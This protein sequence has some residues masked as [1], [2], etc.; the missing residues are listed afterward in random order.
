MKKLSTV[1]AALLATGAIAFSPSVD[2]A[3]STPSSTEHVA[4]NYAPEGAQDTDDSAPA[5]TFYASAVGD[6]FKCGGSFG[7]LWCK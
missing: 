7:K 2:A 4:D 3:A 6:M 1:A 5:V